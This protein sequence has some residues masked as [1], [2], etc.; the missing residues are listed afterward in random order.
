M[1][2][3]Q[4]LR[5]SKCTDDEWYEYCQMQQVRSRPFRATQSH[6]EWKQRI[7]SRLQYFKENDLLP[8]RE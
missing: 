4:H 6:G 1:I 2:T 3:I 5:G 8:I 7:W